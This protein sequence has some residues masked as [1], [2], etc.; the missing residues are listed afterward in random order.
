[1]NFYSRANSGVPDSQQPTGGQIIRIFVE[2]IVR[3][4]KRLKCTEAAIKVYI[5]HKELCLC[6]FLTVSF[7]R[8]YL[9][10]IDK[11]FKRAFRFRCT[12]NLYVITEV[13]EN[14][15]SGPQS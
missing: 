8:K 9:D 7:Q 15:L 12:N 5:P 4:I 2:F 1:M 14:P 6:Y 10:R 13:I 3:S 11:L